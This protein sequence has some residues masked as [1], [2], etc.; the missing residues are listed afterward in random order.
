[1][2]YA[3]RGDCRVAAVILRQGVEHEFDPGG[4]PQF[5]EN[6]EQIILDSMLAKLSL[7]VNLGK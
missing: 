2:R 3:Q 1:L 4:D 6:F 7:N 5:L